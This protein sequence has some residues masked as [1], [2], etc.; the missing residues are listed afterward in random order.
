MAHPVY[1]FL[2]DFES[3]WKPSKH[4]DYSDFWIWQIESWMLLCSFESWTWYNCNFVHFK[5]LGTSLKV[6]VTLQCR[7]R[8][9]QSFENCRLLKFFKIEPSDKC[10]T[11]KISIDFMQYISKKMIYSSEQ[12]A[13]IMC[14]VVWSQY[15]RQHGA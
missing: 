7:I 8:V 15:E 9:P 4:Y 11:N 10:P 1:L 14:G 13:I 3:Y 6:V 2:V 5:L 12:S